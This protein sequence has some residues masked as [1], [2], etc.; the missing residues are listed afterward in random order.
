MKDDVRIAGVGMTR[1][2]RATDESLRTLLE[3]AATRA[4]DDAGVD[5][6][7]LASVHVGSMGSGAFNRRSGLAN[8]LT[9]SLGAFGARADR[10]E[11]TSASGASAFLRGVEAVASGASET[12]LV[13]GAEKMSAAPTAVATDVIS[14]TTHEREYAQGLTLPS[15]GGLAADGYLRRYDA[16]PDALRAVAVKNHANGARNPYAQF[17]TEI[18]LAEARESPMIADPLRLYDCSPMSDGAAAVVLSA[19]DGDVRVAASTGAVGTLAVGNRPDPL[20]FESVAT[21]GRRAFRE[22][23]VA[24]GDVD[25]ASIHDAFTIL[26]LLELEELGFFEPGTA[27]AA[28]LD[29]ETALDGRLPVNP[30]G[31]L[32]ARGHPLGATGVSQVVEL[33]WQLRGEAT[34]RQ[35]SGARVGLAVNVA[36]FG[37]NAVA[38]VLD[39]RVR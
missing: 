33:V 27:W 34:D 32:K 5:P 13:V 1:F 24:R 10:V 7:S 21:A 30:G 9:A 38:T 11:N 26:E 8:L 25:V 2:R 4:L 6:R 20:A 15:F 14:S 39:G 37:N 12:A 22:A 35:V 29:G 16:D 17:Q 36:G 28:T 18:T 3:R 31:G 23:G 19:D